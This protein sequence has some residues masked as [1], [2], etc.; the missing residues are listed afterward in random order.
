MGNFSLGIGTVLIPLG[1]VFIFLGLEKEVVG[2][3]LFGLLF[4]GGVAISMGM[5]YTKK[6][7]EFFKESDKQSDKRFRDLIKEIR[8][9]KYGSRNND[10]PKDSL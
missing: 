9:V 6:A 8:G 4:F 3:P 5:Y 1:F 10:N 2:W 7:Q